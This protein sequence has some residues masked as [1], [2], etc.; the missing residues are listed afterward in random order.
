[1][2]ISGSSAKLWTIPKAG[3]SWNTATAT[4]RDATK[5]GTRQTAAMVTIAMM[6]R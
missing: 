6:Q 2:A 1:M 3:L 5:T 4:A